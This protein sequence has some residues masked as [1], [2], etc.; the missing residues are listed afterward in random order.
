M[1]QIYM[2]YAASSPGT[3]P[4]VTGGLTAYL[5]DNLHLN[6]GRNFEGLE[7]SL[8][9]L[10]ARKALAELFEISHASN[11][12]FTSG[13]TASLN[14]ILNGILKPGDHVLASGLE[15]NAVARPLE[16][17][18]RNGII[19]VEYL[20]HNQDG[21]MDADMIHTRIKPHT[22]LLVMTH[23]SN[24]LGT[25][26]PIKE[27]FAIAKSY[28][29]TTVLDAAQTAG[30][31]PVSMD[32]DTD[33]LAFT[34]H[35][36][37]H[38][39]AGIGGFVLKDGISDQIRPWF[40]G[41]TGSAS[42]QLMQPDFLP[43]KFE[44]GTPNTLGILSLALSV[45]E[46]C[47]IGIH[48]IRTKEVELTQRFRAYCHQIPELII[49]GPE[50]A[51]KTVAVVSVHCPHIDSG[52]LARRLYEEHGIITRSGLHCAPLAHQVAGTFPEGTLRFS[53]G[54]DTTMEDIDITCKA[55]EQVLKTEM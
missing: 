31:Y 6:A 33:I 2:N 47:K 36:A 12:L 32:K 37:L 14:M 13:V 44:P 18:R 8:I 46:I 10:R 16:L 9:A 42:M 15:H 41:G 3:S 34:G 23:A 49:D 4:Y 22:R 28:G 26:L 55:L 21:S 50:D 7:D 53:F 17:L 25:I 29:I 20:P 39:L 5:N 19:E 38:G 43:D 11:V 35:K 51:S 52:V 27:S 48:E 1:K 40:T 54:Y 30:C 24:V 45:E